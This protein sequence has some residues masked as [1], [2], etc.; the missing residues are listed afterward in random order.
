MLLQVSQLD[1][2]MKPL[3]AYGTIVRDGPQPVLGLFSNPSDAGLFLALSLPM[4]LFLAHPADA[5]I[6]AL[7]SLG[8]FLSKSTMAMGTLGVVLAGYLLWRFWDRKISV[9]WAFAVLPLSVAFAAWFS[10]VDPIK[11]QGMRLVIWKRSLIIL[12]KFF[13][14]FGM[15]PGAMGNKWQFVYIDSRW[16]M[17]FSEYM[18][19]LFNHGII[20]LVLLFTVLVFTV[21]RCFKVKMEPWA[22]MGLLAVGAAAT[23]SIPFHVMPTAILAA[24]YLGNIWAMEEGR[25]C[26]GL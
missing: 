25:L 17:L 18:E 1:P 4:A 6:V 19:A 7:L 15:G 11:E 24:W 10:L 12:Q 14:L 20:G 16:T 23:A 21:R 9:R 26:E 5:A 2:I 3:T 22:W 13:P 8:V